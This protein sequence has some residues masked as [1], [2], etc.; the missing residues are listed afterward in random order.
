MG[1]ILS[2]SMEFFFLLF[3]ASRTCSYKSCHKDLYISKLIISKTKNLDTNILQ[4]F[5]IGN[6]YQC[7]TDGISY[8][9]V[10]KEKF[11]SKFRE[12][13]EFHFSENNVGHIYHEVN[14]KIS[15]S[16]TNMGWNLKYQPC[17][18]Y[19]AAGRNG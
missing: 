5:K 13:S 9:V 17:F 3:L 10:S 16:V 11:E 8:E 12:V 19:T 7:I 1:C 14:R 4:N 18:S 2:K 6:S 15:C